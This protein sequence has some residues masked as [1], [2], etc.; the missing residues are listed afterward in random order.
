MI[1]VKARSSFIIERIQVV[2]VLNMFVY[3]KTLNDT[4]CICMFGLI[5]D[6]TLQKDQYILGI[7]MYGTTTFNVIFTHW[8]SH[9][10]NIKKSPFRSPGFILKRWLFLDS[11]DYLFRIS[12]V[13]I[14][15]QQLRNIIVETRSIQNINI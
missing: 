11:S 6:K 14:L 1:Q 2:F 9:F 7:K 3:V 10:F 8:Q 5:W 13:F 12:K 15:Q 4:V